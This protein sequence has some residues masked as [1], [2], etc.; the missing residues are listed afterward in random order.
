MYLKTITELFCFIDALKFKEMFEEAGKENKKLAVPSKWSF[1]ILLKIIFLDKLNLLFLVHFK[2]IAMFIANTIINYIH[3][4]L[5][6]NI[7]LPIVYPVALCFRWC[8]RNR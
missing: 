8:V 7:L 1:C 5:S 6:T 3:I 4:F 2:F